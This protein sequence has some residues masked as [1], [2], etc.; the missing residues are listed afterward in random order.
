MRGLV[1][2]HQLEGGILAH[3]NISSYEKMLAFRVDNH[4]FNCSQFLFCLLLASRVLAKMTKVLVNLLADKQVY[5]LVY[6]DVWLV[7]VP[8][9]H[10]ASHDVHTIIS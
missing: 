2:G 4:T 1:G 3:S 6:L 8:S 7:S 5:I 9:V 10:K